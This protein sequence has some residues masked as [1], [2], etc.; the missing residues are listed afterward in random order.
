MQIGDTNYFVSDHGNVRG[1]RGSV[2]IRTVNKRLSVN[3]G[4]QTTTVS[5]HR[6]VAKHFVDN[7]ENFSFVRHIDGNFSNNHY[8]NLKWAMKQIH[9][10][11]CCRCKEHKEEK[12][13]RI[14]TIKKVIST[15]ELRIY[16]RRRT[17]CSP[18]LDKQRNILAKKNAFTKIHEIFNQLKN[19]AGVHPNGNTV[20]GIT[21]TRTRKLD[22]IRSPT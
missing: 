21:D 1:L 4:H 2:R 18:C 11:I 16:K 7:P 3:L 19:D 13:F 15:G 14:V 9:T 6:L 10:G 12:L 8:T 5:V 20:Q 17:T 22:N